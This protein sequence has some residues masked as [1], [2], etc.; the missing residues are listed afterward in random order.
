M[1]EVLVAIVITAIIVVVLIAI[2][3][4]ATDTWKDGRDQASASHKANAALNQLG[5]DLETMM[6]RS[7]NN[8]EWLY[9]TVDPDSMD[10]GPDGSGGGDRNAANMAQ[11]VFLTTASDRYDGD[12]GGSGDAGGDV[13]CVG[14]RL[15]FRNE[16][17]E[18]TGATG[19]ATT[20]PTFAMYRHLV[21]PDDAYGTVL[22]VTD[23]QSAYATNHQANDLN[24]NTLLVENIYEFSIIFTLEYEY[25]D[26]NSG[27]IVTG[28]KMV[29][30][31][32]R[33]LESDGTTALDKDRFAEYLRIKGNKIESDCLVGDIDGNGTDDEP[34]VLITNTTKMYNLRVTAATVSVTVLSNDGI[35]ELKLFPNSDRSTIIKKYGRSYSKTVSLPRP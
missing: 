2:T 15:G 14:Y 10:V 22:A 19:S 5:R 31:N 27:A 35:R 13:S 23:L 3:R 26:T 18:L 8:Y 24:A 32:P 33:G 34:G 25:E 12:I 21:E 4:L 9:V 7:G 20:D 29:V 16:V 6:L 1:V 28:Q 17:A 30:I 11:L